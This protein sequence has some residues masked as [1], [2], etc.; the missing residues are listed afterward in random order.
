MR[1]NASIDQLRILLTGL[2][3]L[4]HAAIVYGGAGGW[5]WRQEADGSNALLVLFNAVNQSYFMGFFFLLAG[6][7][8]PQSFDRKGTRQF[9]ADRFLRLGLPLAAYFFI[10]SPM[11]IALART[12]EGHSFFAGWW[13]MERLGNFEPGPLWFAEALLIF[14]LAYVGV[15]TLRPGSPANLQALPGYKVIT[16]AA[17]AA[18][19]VSFLVRLAVPTGKSVLWLQLGYFPPYVL[20]FLV[21]C[22]AARNRVFDRVTFSDAKPW[23]IVSFAMLVMLPVV[24]VTG[25]GHGPFNGGWNWNAGF[26]AFWDPFVAWGIILTLFWVAGRY[27][28]KG[29][30]LA[31]WLARRAFGA[32]IVH[33]PVLVALSLSARGW[34]AV[35]L[36]K[37]AAVGPAAVA[38]SFV[39]ASAALLV[40]GVRRIV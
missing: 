31:D 5:Y 23:A 17:L 25:R 30:P 39:A 40:P 33:P 35:P 16:I 20:L 15:R 38:V 1:R 22:L 27:W 32:Y 9:L 34:T 8:T 13:L 12:G 21:G 2:V 26:Y 14:A 10:L 11:T 4:H 19:C 24:I 29:S 18:G 6:Y 3:I 36:L 7:Y 37:F 28:A